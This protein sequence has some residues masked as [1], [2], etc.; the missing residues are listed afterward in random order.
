MS[1]NSHASSKKQ[2]PILDMRN[3]KTNASTGNF[4]Q[5]R[6]PFLC[7]LPMDVYSAVNSEEHY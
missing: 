3:S 4:L 1:A 6:N 2:S 7:Y 5:T